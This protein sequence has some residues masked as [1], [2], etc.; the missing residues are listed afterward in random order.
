MRAAGWK[1]FMH[2][3]SARELKLELIR[4]LLVPLSTDARGGGAFEHSAT[5]TRRLGHFFATFGLGVH[6][7]GKQRFNLAVRV[8]R[9]SLQRHPALEDIQRRAA[10]EV[11]V[12]YVGPVFKLQSDRFRGRQ[13]PLR[14]GNSVGHHEITAGTLGCFVQTRGGTPAMV[15]NNHVLANENQGL[16]GDAIVQPA[17]LDG[18]DED[19]D[20]V[21]SLSSF[22]PLQLDE[23]NL[24]DCA[25]AGLD[26]GVDF[27][28]ATLLD[29]IGPAGS[30]DVIEA[31]RN[32]VEKLGRTTG[33]TRGRISA[34]EID[35]LTVSYDMGVLRF[36]DQIE[37]ETAEEGPFSLGG[38][39]GSL[40]YGAETGL[41]FGLLFAGSDQGGPNGLGLSYLNPLGTV[42][43]ELDVELLT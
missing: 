6:P 1:E 5:S 42:L 20:R 4:D 28:A 8:Q 16:I 13:R 10:A 17:P 39:S 30:G 43:S 38:D 11:D 29:D 2:L 25:V 14:I 18:G 40:V 35:N 19:R 23:P 27:E 34:F 7:A 33:R 24:V 41:A 31:G 37:V 36:D 26:E 3:D 9:R 12:R 32:E 21:A 22:E 15:S